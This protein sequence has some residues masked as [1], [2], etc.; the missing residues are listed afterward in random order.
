MH[1]AQII[2]Q[3]TVMP[4]QD[5]PKVLQPSEQPLDFPALPIAAQ[6]SAI[7]GLRFLPVRLMRGN[8]LNTPGLQSFIQRITIIRLVA[9]QS[10]RS[11]F[12]KTSFQRGLHQRHFMRRS[13]AK[14][15]GDRKTSAVCHCHDL[16]TFAPLG[17]SHPWAPFFAMTK[18]PSMKHSVKSNPP[19]SFTS[20]SNARKIASNTPERTHS[21]KRRWQVWYGG[22]LSGM[23]FHCAPVRMIHKIPSRTSRLSRRGLPR[24][25]GRFGGSGMSGRII[26]HCSSVRSIGSLPFG[27]R[28]GVYHF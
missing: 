24:P 21:W 26:A 6:R 15:Y 7:L 16:C 11:L 5:P 9:N 14:G 2:F 20:F 3:K 23:S 10:F 27:I 18:V 28:A 19:R 4:N 1:E 25:S 13:T 22:Y 8:Q 12:R 17:F